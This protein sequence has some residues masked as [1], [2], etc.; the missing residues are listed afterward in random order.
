MSDFSVPENDSP[1][2][3]AADLRALRLSK[4][5]PTLDRLARE[6]HISRTVISETFNGRQFP[7]ARTVDR[8]VKALD[9]DAQAWVARR[10]RLAQTRSQ[11]EDA[12]P[13]E[14]AAVRLVRRRTAG[15]LAVAALVVGM[16]VGGGAGFAGGSAYMAATPLAERTQITVQNGL[17]PAKTACVNDA[18]VAVA[19]DRPHNT[20][21][22]IIWS[23]KCG[24][25]WA[26]VTRYDENEAGNTMS[27]SIY[28]QSN[29]DSEDRQTAEYANVRGMY[30]TLLVRPGD[31]MLCA[32]AEMTLG[33][34]VI[35]LGEPLCT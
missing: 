10:D 28:P 9:G 11:G 14:E 31:D 19:S 34:E 25:G 24:A 7:S 17:D 20:L 29:P 3:F 26:R 27:V 5:Q 13:E 30:T 33:E 23:N 35:D 18:E 16:V 21:L 4:N 8:I 32:E 15:V 2:A 12:A 1:E 22:E 6:A